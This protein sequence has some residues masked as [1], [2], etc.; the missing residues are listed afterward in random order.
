[1]SK[2]ELVPIDFDEIVRETDK[3][4][5]FKTAV[6]EVWIPKSQIE[7]EGDDVIMIPEWLAIEK[8]LV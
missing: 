2:N 8:G 5:L 7:D 1:M 4:K 3:A 6:G